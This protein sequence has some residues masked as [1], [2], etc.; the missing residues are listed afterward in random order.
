MDIYRHTQRGTVIP[1][2]LAGGSLVVAIGLNIRGDNALLLAVLV[3]LVVTA[4]LF[5]S[6]TIE[7]NGGLLKLSFGLGLLH[8]RVH[9]A[10]IQACAVVENPWWYGWGIHWTP[11]G[12]LYNVAGHRAVEITLKG[13]QRFRIGTDEP[14]HLCQALQ[15]AVA[16]VRV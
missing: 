13:G 10:G 15:R 4:L 5:A 2:L 16:E 11:H 7:I 12:L 8:K 3:V 6:L 9:V 14:E 1:A